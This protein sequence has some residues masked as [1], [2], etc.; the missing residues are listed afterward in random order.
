MRSSWKWLVVAL[1]ATGFALAGCSKDEDDDSNPTGPTGENGTTVE[2]N[3]TSYDYYVY[4]NLADGAE[5]TLADADAATSSDWHIAFKRY[6]VKLNG[7]VSGPLGLTAIDMGEVDFDTVAAVPETAPEDWT[8]DS[9]RL[10]FDGW[11]D[12]DFTAHTIN[13]S[14][15]LFAF[16][17]ADGGY[18]K[19]VVT[20]ITDYTQTS[21]GSVTLKYVYD[22]DGTDLS[23]D[24]VTVTITDDAGDGTLFFSFAA[25]GAVTVTDPAASTD[26]D[27]WFDGFDAK[28]N[29][30]VNGPG[31]AAIYPIYDETNDF[32]GLTS[33]PPDMGAGYQTDSI[34]S[35]F[36]NWYSYDGTTHELTSNGHVY[37]IHAGGE[38]YYKLS[39]DNYYKVIDGSPVSGWITFR[40]EEL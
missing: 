35:I 33:A 27:I 21:V 4:Y 25:G 30:G 36:D 23:G 5:I 24:P 31:M 8:A 38:T 37:L 9:Y 19:L 18:A 29:G 14:G 6:S 39:I 12:Y 11:Y 3:A 20:E 22:P 1:L 2:L 28:I 26:W 15:R 13:P 10:I 7:G 34:S 16:R 32:D 17:T 40:Y